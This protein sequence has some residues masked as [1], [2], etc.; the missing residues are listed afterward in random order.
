[1]NWHDYISVDPT[2]M[3]GIACIAGTR[4][5]VSL[6]LDNLAARVPE[7]RL[8][9]EYPSLTPEAITAALAYAA[10]LTREENE[11]LPA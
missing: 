3:H 9:S 5:P 4:I 2:V 10:E 7:E 11:T 8:L 6:V 1:M